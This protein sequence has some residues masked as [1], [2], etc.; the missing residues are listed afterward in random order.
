MFSYETNWFS[1]R[2]KPRGRPRCPEP[3]P[4]LRI[5]GHEDV[6]DRNPKEF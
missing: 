3:S 2:L 1:G 6:E 5:Y 4:Q